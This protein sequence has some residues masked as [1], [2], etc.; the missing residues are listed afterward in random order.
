VTAPTVVLACGG[1]ETP[2]LL[3]SSRDRLPCGLGNEH[4]LVGRFYMTHVGGTVATLRF[5]EPGA[6]RCFDYARTREGIYARR[7]V[8]L[9]AEA[10]RRAK[11]GNVVFRPNIHPIVDPSH[12]D[13]ILSA[14]AFAK[15][16]V[17]PEYSR[18][19]VLGASDRGTPAQLFLRHSLNIATGI[20]R[21]MNFG[22]DWL[23]RRTFA[24]RKLPSVFLLRRDSSY[25]LAFDA[26]Q[27]PEADSRVSLGDTVD[28]FGMPRL[29]IQ[30]H[31]SD[32]DFASIERA[33]GV[34]A[35][36]ADRTGFADLTLKQD[37]A[38]ELR[39]AVGP[40]GGHHI[41]TARMGTNPRTSV[42]DTH[43]EL[44]NT[45]GVFVAGS[46]VFPTCGFANPTLSAVAIALRMAD[47]L[48]QNPVR[49]RSTA[50]A[51]G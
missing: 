1:L 36:A 40:V 22:V 12:G 51:R 37:M 19:L 6:D 7:L 4:D 24:T 14:M 34:L 48:N 25:P 42:V 8:T 20:P 47:H 2:R 27:T 39:E 10:R 44:W 41:G 23:R 49:V 21:L 50:E 15:K 5:R 32:E 11:I 45:K 30:W 38:A 35:A 17:I 29:A 33:H 28:P 16:L 9:S 46:A 43:C 13:S 18:K 26:E 31:I 3:L